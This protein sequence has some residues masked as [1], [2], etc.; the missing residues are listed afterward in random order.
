MQNQQPDYSLD[1]E[2]YEDQV[3]RLV[4]SAQ[5]R[6]G[7]IPLPLTFDSMRAGLAIVCALLSQVNCDKCEAKC[8]KSLPGNVY[9]LP[10]E[11]EYLSMKSLTQP[12]LFLDGNRCL[13]FHNRHR[14][15]TCIRYPYQPGATSKDGIPAIAL[16]SECPEACRIAKDVY[17][18]FRQMKQKFVD[19]GEE[20]YTEN[21]FGIR[22]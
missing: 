14:P 12:C 4:S 5:S 6:K 16:A 18:T 7:T 1:R 20:G 15:L 11:Q 21:F 22:R 19:V 2:A 17:M 10:S 9:L 3:D 13:I 8:C